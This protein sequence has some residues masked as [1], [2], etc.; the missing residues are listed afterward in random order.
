VWSCALRIA[1]AF[2][3]AASAAV[4][5]PA[6]AQ[7]ADLVVNQA[8]NPDP[9]PAGGVFTYTIRV[10][11]NGPDTAT[12]IS[13][14][15]TLPPGST[16]VS[17]ATTQGTCNPPAAGV[18]NCALGTLTFLANATVTVAVILPTPAVWTN[19]VTATSAVADPNSSNNV[20]VSESTTAQHASDMRLT[21]VDAPDPIAAGGAY[22]Y[23][24]T[25][26]NLGPDAAASQTIAFTVPTGACITAVPTGT[27]WSCAP[28][29]GYPLCSGTITCM[30]SVSLASGASAPNL[31]VPAVANISGSITA[32]FTV[33][34]PLP[35]GDTSNNTP[36][37]TT[38]VNGGSTDLSITKTTNLATVGVGSPVIFTLTPKLNGGQPA[39]QG[40][41]LITVTDSLPAGFTLTST[42]TGTGWTCSAS[43]A[44]P[45]AGPVAITC[46]RVGPF[47]ANFTTMPTITVNATVTS[48]GPLVNTATVSSAETDP[49]PG[50]N[51]ATVTVTGSNNADM[52]ITKAGAANAVF[53]GDDFTYVLTP[54]NNGP[55]AL[56]IG[57]IV[58]VTDPVPLGVTIRSAPTSPGNF[59]TCTVAG[60][61][62]FPIAGP[63]TVTCTR[64]LTAAIASGANMTAI[65]IPVE[66]NNVGSFANTACVALP[67]PTGPSDGNAANNC[68]TNT[69][70]STVVGT[71]A[72]LQA[73]SKTASPDPV[74]AGQNLTYIITVVNNGP[75]PATNVTV[76]DSLTS[77]VTTG[78]FQSA[79]PSQ[80]TCTPNVVTAGPTVNLSCNL[81]ALAVGATATVTVVV[82]P[83]VATSGS[84]TNTATVRSPD[85]A[86]PVDTNNSASA[87]S[88]VTAVA[89]VTVTKT[90]SPDPAQAGTNLTYVI[91]ARNNGPSTAAAVTITDTLP[92]NARFLS[93][94]ATTGG[95][96]CTTPTILST[97]GTLTC[98][99]ATIA[100]GSQQ[101]ATVV[102]RPVTGATTVV[103]NV[104]VSTTTTESN[105]ANNA[106][107]ASTTITPASVD[108]VINKVDSVDPV[109]LGS[110]TKYTIAVTNSGP[111]EATNVVMTDTFPVGSPTATFSYQGNLT[112]APAG[113]GSC[114]EPPL[115][116]TSGTITCTF[117][118]VAPG[119]GN[120][121]LVTY[122]M[123][124]E[125]IASG[126][127]GTTFNGAS[128]TGNE[129]ES[130]LANNL[131]VNSTTTRQAADLG[132]VKTGPASV[133]PGNTVAW[134]LTVTNNGPADS[135]GAQVTDA[136]PTGV[137]FV[138]ASP[139]CALAAG[140][141]TCTLGL[142]SVGN[143]TAFTINV[144]V[145]DP[146]TGAFPLSN[147]ATVAAVNEIDVVTGNNSSVATT[148]V[149]PQADLGVLKTVNNPTPVVGG[150]VQ[151]TV[152]VTN[153]GPNGAAGAQVADVLPAGYSFVSAVPSQGS[154]NSSTGVWTIGSIAHGASVT[155]AVNATVNASG[156]T[157]NTATVSATTTD[158]IPGNNTSSAGTAPVAQADLAITKNVNNGTPNVGSN[159]TF[160]I[161]VSNLGPSSA[162]N[163]QVSDALPA[164]Y[165]FVSA[166][167]SIG[168]Y[169]SGTGIWS[170]IGT[171]A[172]GGSASMTVTATVA[173]SG[174]YLNTATASTTTTEPNLA[175]NSAS[176]NVSP[177]AV[178]SLAVTKTD[179]SATYTPGGTGTYVIVVT[180]G[181]PSA[182]SSVTLTDS[183]PAGVTLGATVTCTVTG[184]A[185][186]GTVSG[187]AGQTALGTTGATIAAG[188]GNS[189]TF[190]VPVAY[191][192]SMTTATLVNT[193][194]VTDPASPPASG[195]DS[196][197][198][199]AS[200][201]LDVTKTDGSNTYTPG[202]TATYVVTVKNSGPSDAA[203]VTVNDALPAGVTLTAAVTCTPNGVANC[204]TVTGS[205]GQASFGTTGA[206]LGASTG[207]SLVFTVPVAF[208][209]GMTADPLVNTAAT[210]D[211]ATGAT[212]NG[213]DSDALAEQVSLAVT[214]TDGSNSYTPGGSAAYT[215]TVG[216][217][218][219][220]TANAVTVADSLPPGVT[221]S[222]TVS[223]TTGGTSSCGTLSGAAGETSFG[224][225]GAIVVPGAGNEI[226]FTVPV[227]FAASM[228]TDPLVNTA[229]ATDGPSGATGAGSDSDARSAQVTLVV[230][231]SDN[232][233]T[234]V[235]GGTGLYVVT[236]RNTGTSDA[237]DVTVND[238]LP[239]G[240]VL[241]GAV[242]CVV[243]GIATCGLVTG[244]AGQ[245]TF[246]ATGAGLGTG[247]AD[248]LVFTAPVAFAPTLADDPL[249]NTA[250]ATDLAS[251][252]TASGSDSDALD[253][254][255]ALAIAKTDGSDTYA[256]GGT[257]TYTVVVTNTGLSAA[258]S[259]TVSD[260]LPAGVTLTAS[261]LCVPAGTA[262]CGTVTG[263]AGETDFGTNGASIGAGGGDSLTFTAP[264]AYTA[265][266]TTDPLVNTAVASDGVH[267]PVSASD[268]DA[269][270]ANVVLAVTKTDGTS[271]YVPGS[272]G[273]YTIVV[274]N[275]GSSDAGNVSV[276]DALPTGVTLN[277][278]VTCN[279][280]GN[281]GCGVISGVPDLT[282][283]G[284][285]VGAGA[286]NA[287]TYTMPVSFA[288]GLVTA[289]IT[290]IVT[291]TDIPTG[292]SATASDT[293]SL[294]QI[295]PAMTKAI[296]PA[297]IN[298]GGTAALTITLSNANAGP[299][300]L[301]APFVDA[302]PA[303]VT[304]IGGNAGT[305]ADVAVTAT[306]ITMASGAAIP[307]GGCAIVVT[308][309][310][311]ST[312]TV[313]NITG[314]LSTSGGSAPPASAPI[315]VTG[316]GGGIGSVTK[317]IVPAV[318]S[319]GGRA[320]MTITLGNA[321][322]GPL[323][324]TAPFSDPMPVGMSIVSANTGTCVGVGTTTTL[325]TLPAG[326]SIPPGGCTIIVAVTS[327]T[328][329]NAVNV[330]SA[331][332]A[333]SVTAPA[334]SAPLAVAAA[335]PSVE[336]VPTLSPLGLVLPLL[337]LAVLGGLYLRRRR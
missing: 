100:T 9:G 11:N 322:A 65:T 182:A 48:I 136:L 209:P 241:T 191:A 221:L 13:F 125:S 99:W 283:T 208:A 246:A 183:M 251:G 225:T 298:V 178:A 282:V 263:G 180:N 69:V 114:V 56:P 196:S 78:G 318:I 45:A 268:I 139:G 121:I 19:V 335:N 83:L 210:T 330:T 115:N 21:V 177:V 233:T 174:S 94:S 167:P 113:S 321:G 299:L 287:L 269:L 215:I 2:A 199:E 219:L 107:S 23:A 201:A 316:A 12:G 265:D 319:I 135:N 314:T 206:T 313:T 252:A 50:N 250:T 44:A 309:T 102:V 274:T 204:G 52:T 66:T 104:I 95:P 132:I 14:A 24:L 194:D 151:F 273:T 333:G 150:T 312:G 286:G 267:P 249:V 236:V 237:V 32:A 59:W 90:D 336:S 118:D 315:T 3:F 211:V 155:M 197:T 328:P 57:T 329:G 186:C 120:S 162:A 184:I 93:L 79:T 103:N 235:P 243:N 117:P 259:V 231:K 71:G 72:D 302:M 35:D 43:P 202:G 161:A 39:G 116:V 17:A 256:P 168:S 6:L 73:V 122:D 213:S 205:N 275:T 123:R 88:Q 47:S 279:A 323:T 157:T 154:Y 38:T 293:D 96:T 218:G 181:G 53:I 306:T 332:V 189:L 68:A 334:A 141:V 87:T 192:S 198:R 16:F 326:S 164:G 160:T 228:I 145:N 261:A 244:G 255:P 129:P 89:D 290:N 126:T 37:A 240:V 5:T 15:D 152:A 147:T 281:A 303:G 8:D 86:D 292:S 149:T 238:P 232:S 41:G 31:N 217:G 297:T 278:P 224:T 61:P 20:N 60:A 30:R 195:S 271:T 26:T 222:G 36:T 81:G 325:I 33:S 331:L 40:G 77:L 295:G 280:A 85:I 200:V 148:N 247:P 239:V 138:N 62:P 110:L 63:V 291:V 317:A 112:I 324:L 230:T 143:T 320:T 266:M 70:T 165:T 285:R 294:S 144:T 46:T 97:G 337:A 301:A 193:V 308:I 245:T 98:T 248:S 190:S 220:S 234:Y 272:S 169:N 1:T 310:S 187:I 75:S 54:H 253:A 276:N 10:D 82:R 223:C 296:A 34:S 119:S 67:G 29:T 25:A 131:A 158:P 262:N 64:T 288:A 58:Q 51:T 7:S 277:G 49:V 327:S 226:V 188:A 289:T 22:S 91:T 133:I 74:L 171:L 173:P 207:D 311:S 130:S 175:N 159:V 176:A 229:M 216:N 305:C 166:T 242:Q 137:T 254:Q 55:V 156:G 257:G 163:V 128:V 28:N 304:T 179:N 140:K 214:K 260:A 4:A 258:L 42:P 92:S 18:V 153:N 111:S 284:A 134:A 127:S 170:G 300:T 124:A 203:N 227:T 101:T 185:T 109:A 80:G 76:T 146:Y 84:R 105:T 264:V 27:N 212:A 172:S 270:S 108:L 106:A 142:L 307:A